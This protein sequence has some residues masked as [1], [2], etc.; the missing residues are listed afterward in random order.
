MKNQS[1]AQDFK[2]RFGN[3]SKEKLILISIA[4]I[5]FR[6]LLFPLAIIGKAFQLLFAC[7][8]VIPVPSAANRFTKQSELEAYKASSGFDIIKVSTKSFLGFTNNAYG[9]YFKVHSIP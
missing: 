3:Q 7:L 8:F 5:V 2:L 9:A 6:I 4:K 1:S